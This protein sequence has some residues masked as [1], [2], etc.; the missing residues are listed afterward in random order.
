[1]HGPTEFE[2]VT[3][4]DL[5]AK[6]RSAS[7]VACITDFARSQLMRLVPQSEW[8][9]LMVVR[10]GVDLDAYDYAAPRADGDPR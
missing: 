5:A 10:M 6:V 9:K 7:G 3:R 2:N 4:F 8:D 1:M